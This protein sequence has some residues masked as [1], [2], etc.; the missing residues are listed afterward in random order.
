MRNFIKILTVSLLIAASIASCI[1]EEKYSVEQANIHVSLS[2]KASSSTQQGDGIEDVMIWAYMCDLNAD[3]TVNSITQDAPVGWRTATM[4]DGTYTSTNVHIQLP[5]CEGSQS[6][7]IVAVV[8]KSKFGSIVDAQG[9][10]LVLGRDTK[11]S[12]LINAKFANADLINSAITESV[13]PATPTLM[14]VSHWAV[15]TVTNEHAYP[16]SLELSMPVFRAIA[17]TQ[18]FMAKMSDFD[19]TVNSLELYCN[20][21][22][23]DGVVLSALNVADL[24]S[25]LS[26]PTPTWLGTATPTATTAQSY[27][28]VSGDNTAAVTAVRESRP[29]I[30]AGETA[31]NYYTHIGAHF[32]HETA[33]ACT[34]AADYETNG[35]AIPTGNGFYYKIQYTVGADS[36]PLTRYVAIPN[37]IVRNRDYQV[38]ALVRADGQIDVN[39]V[40]AEWDDVEWNLD[41]DAPVHTQLL[42]SADIN[43]TAPKYAPVVYF[44]NSDDTGEKGAFTGYFMMEGP[45]G[46][47]W[48]PTLTNASADD[49][50]VRVYTN[51]DKNGATHADYDILVTDAN[52]EAE[53]NR[54]YKIVVV[55]KNQNNINKVVKLGITYAPIWNEEASPLLI[56]NKGDGE[57]DCY[58]PWTATGNTKD[59]PDMFWISIKQVSS[60]NNQ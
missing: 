8:N 57:G 11:Y 53:D 6:Y 47:T 24:N 12:E 31:Y 60:S 40:V 15:C 56:I 35:S 52:I 32:M 9:Q 17:K 37:A 43:A 22:P 39:Y 2:T 23:E 44:D 42:T 19:L 21:L 58:Y 14:P 10:S 38:H 36:S 1:K 51:I 5:M 50:Q 28:L 4:P 26:T 45:L 20:Q 18:F 25:T 55:A 3:G 49:Y 30:G 13:N 59:N 29:T 48:K 27:T 7:L 46:V 54:F 16:N 33:E 41:F 34:N